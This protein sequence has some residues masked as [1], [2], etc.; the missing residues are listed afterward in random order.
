MEQFAF[1]LESSLGAVI[2][3][4]AAIGWLVGCAG[5]IAHE[6]VSRIEDRRLPRAEVR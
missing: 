2:A 5:M 6:I 3:V 1:A 4:L